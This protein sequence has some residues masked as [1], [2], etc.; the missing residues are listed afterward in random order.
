MGN[1]EAALILSEY[2]AYGAQWDYALWQLADLPETASASDMAR[3]ICERFK[4]GEEM[5]DAAS[6]ELLDPS[7]LGALWEKWAPRY[8]CMAHLV[9]EL[10]VLE[11]ER[12]RGRPSYPT[13]EKY[14]DMP[15]AVLLEEV[16]AYN[17][18]PVQKAALSKLRRQDKDLYVK[19][20]DTDNPFAWWLAFECLS[21][22]RMAEPVYATALQKSVEYLPV[23]ESS[24]EPAGLKSQKRLVI[25]AIL[26]ALP[27]EMTLPYARRWFNSPGWQ[28][29]R[30]ANDLLH[31]H[32]TI[33]DFPVVYAAL[34]E[35]LRE[36]PD[37]MNGYYEVCDLLQILT[38]FAGIGPLP[39]VER[40]FVETDWSYA[41]EW[42][43]RAMASNA[44]D[45]F[46]RG[47]AFECL[48]DADEDIRVIGCESVAL[49]VPGAAE[50]LRA[51]AD[52]PFEDESVR[53]AAR[54]RSPTA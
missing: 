15:T 2:V 54:K 32:A 6:G 53:E 50:R 35:M 36:T 33:D 38:G 34:A 7:W 49:D 20:F 45:W 29:S 26:E 30:L 18:R 19:A 28:L 8:P 16:G 25:T 47:Y 17:W 14:T 24:E 5:D 4:S 48:W 41:R 40:V 12:K 52:D 31:E 13:P 43:A 44:Q 42:A 39:E 9:E 21:A 37:M 11:E 23:L 27:P 46:A 10:N 3:A 51:L 1:A 22:L